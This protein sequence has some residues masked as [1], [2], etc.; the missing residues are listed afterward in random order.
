MKVDGHN[1][2]SQIAFQF[3][4]HKLLSPDQ[5]EVLNTLKV[6]NIY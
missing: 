3:L 4:S 5:Y 2:A 1:E 6:N